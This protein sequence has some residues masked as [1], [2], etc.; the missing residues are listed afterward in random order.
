MVDEMKL[1]VSTMFMRSFVAKLIKD[2]IRKKYGCNVDIQLNRLNVEIVD[3][4]ARLHTDIEASTDNDELID[5]LKNI[6]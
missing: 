3:G 4:K 5:I 2:F 6:M 1:K